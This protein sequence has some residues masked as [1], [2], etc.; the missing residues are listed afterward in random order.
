MQKK[1]CYTRVQLRPLKDQTAQT[2]AD[3]VADTT[4]NDW[5]VP[6]TRIIASTADNC[7]TNMGDKGGVM[8]I[9]STLFG[10][11]WIFGCLAHK[12]N[13]LV[14]YALKALVYYIATK[15]IVKRL[16]IFVRGSTKRGKRLQLLCDAAGASTRHVNKT[17]EIRW[18]SREEVIK[19]LFYKLLGILDFLKEQ[20]EIEELAEAEWLYYRVSN[21][22]FLLYLFKISDILVILGLLLRYFQSNWMFV[23]RIGSR[24][25]KLN[26]KLLLY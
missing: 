3:T 6:H 20:S 18:L 8:T 21:I 4:I 5:E 1:F 14:S 22:Y 15:K 7:N 13:L 23:G 10:I 25:R 2:I 26:K 11:F 19:V 16:I 17:F 24:I 12:L 9:L